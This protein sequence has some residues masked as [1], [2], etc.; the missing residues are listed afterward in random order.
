MKKL[1]ILLLL[2]INTTLF[3]QS[4][5]KLRANSFCEK[6]TVYG[7]WTEF[8]SWKETNILIVID[9]DKQRVTVYSAQ[10]QTYDIIT[11]DGLSL[12]EFGERTQNYT[13]IDEN[14]VQ[15]RMRVIERSQSTN[16]IFDFANIIFCYNVHE[17]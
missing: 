14:G 10:T 15:C 16:I 17:I 3:G 8:T 4:V 12:S 9:G 7:Q 2:L 1:L 11:N 6:H 13:C 5:V